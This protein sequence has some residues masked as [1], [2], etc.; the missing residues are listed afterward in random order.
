VSGRAPNGER[1]PK[2]EVIDRDLSAIDE[3]CEQ[4]RAAYR[5]SYEY[6]L[7][8]PGAGG[9]AL[10]SGS[11]WRLGEDADPTGATVVAGD[12]EHIRAAARRIARAI[13]RTRRELE[14]ASNEALGAFLDLDP[15]LARD[16]AEARLLA[17]AARRSEPGR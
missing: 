16:R 8:R 17:A 11:G 1:L 9:L 6:G 14:R 10:T 7:S 15:D 13:G 3:L 5:E 2:P 12:R 4:L